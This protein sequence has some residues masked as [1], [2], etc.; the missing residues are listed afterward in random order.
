M[1][2]LIAI[3][4]DSK[5]KA[6]TALKRAAEMQKQHLIDLGDAVIVSRDENG[7]V[8]LRQSTNLVAVGAASGG[9]W[10]T[11]IGLLFLNPLLGLAVGA[12]SGALGGFFTDIGIND[13]FMK[14][15]GQELQPGTSALFAL[16]RKSTP[17]RV[18]PEVKKLGGTVFTTSLSQEEERQLRDAL[19]GEAQRRFS[20]A[21][22]D[23]KESEPSAEPVRQDA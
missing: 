20:A 21:E 23:R 15:M 14:R 22:P 17:D 9:V 1:A 7:K 2:D 10:G 6:E 16:V 19:E 5:D 12:A 11:L 8:S 4:F 13:D 3:T 18:L